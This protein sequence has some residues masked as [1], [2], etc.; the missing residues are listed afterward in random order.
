MLLEGLQGNRALGALT[1][2][3]TDR[4][5]FIGGRIRHAA[6]LLAVSGASLDSLQENP[7]KVAMDV[8]KLLGADAVFGPA[9]PIPDSS[10]GAN[11]HIQTK[12]E[13]QTPEDIL[14]YIEKLPPVED[15]IKS[16]DTDEVY[17][18][19]L[20]EYEQG[21]HE[22][23]KAL[24]IPFGIGAT[25]DYQGYYDL[26]GMEPFLMAL[27]L[28]EEEMNALFKRSAAIAQYKNS[29]AA[30]MFSQEHLPKFLWFGHDICDNKGPMVSPSIL[31]RIYFPHA[32]A[33][34]AP[35]RDAGIRIIWHSD[36]N[37]MPIAKALLNVVGVDG[38]QG[39]QMELGVDYRVLGEM[40]TMRGEKPLLVGG[41]NNQTLMF[42]EP[43]DIRKE[44]D[45]FAQYA[46]QRGG[47]CLLGPS[48]SSGPEISLENLQTMYRYASS[49]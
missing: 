46:K 28:Y 12:S 15:V 1:F 41:V 22:A 38:F 37:I 13:I 3:P 17:A 5:P 23:K 29:I 18:R 19:M 25:A 44:I 30:R 49:L 6:F 42:G 35:L 40:R 7:R 11:M 21:Y 32:A 20:M 47:G 2:H 33:A 34:V 27:V 36:G 8:A 48:C 39:F 26:F 14:T 45:M 4:V 24:F 31:E 16:I 43:E 9:F 10:I